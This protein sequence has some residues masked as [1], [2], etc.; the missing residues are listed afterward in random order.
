VLQS[1][2]HTQIFEGI[3]CNKYTLLNVSISSTDSNLKLA[4]GPS[5][6]LYSVVPHLNME[7]NILHTLLQPED[8]EST[9][10]LKK[11]KQQKCYLK[12]LYISLNFVDFSP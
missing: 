11:L 3:H 12:L 4:P 8:T 2:G 6:Q 9:R 1:T 10:F 5:P 7:R